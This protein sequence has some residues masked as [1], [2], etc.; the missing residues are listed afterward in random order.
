MRELPWRHAAPPRGIGLRA[1]RRRRREGRRQVLP[2]P[3]A[4]KAKTAAFPTTVTT[5]FDPRL[6]GLPF[7]NLGDYASEG[8]CIGMSLLAVDSY[9]RRIAAEQ[10]G[11][12]PATAPTLPDNPASVDME[13]RDSVTASL[14]Q[15]TQVKNLDSGADN[16][17]EELKL[18]NPKNIR[19]ALERSREDQ[20]SRDH[21]PQ[22]GQ[23][24][25]R[26]GPLRLQGREAPDLRSQ[27]PGGDG[28]VAVRPGEGPRPP[29]EGE[30]RSHVLRQAQARREHALRPVPDGARYRGDPLVVRCARQGLRRALRDGHGEGRASEQRRPPTS[31]GQGLG[32]PQEDGRRHEAREA[33]ERLDRRERQDRRHG[34]RGEGRGPSGCRCPR[35]SSTS[36]RTT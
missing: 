12:P 23:R 18:S 24:R 14:A 19:A 9:K 36:P 35:R 3:A 20:R 6:H 29:P 21:D 11:A 15:E 26:D 30:G 4:P 10:A 7:P 13:G 33:E 34:S 2:L 28:R 16:V 25:P 32:R 27:L 8:N 22:L 1:P 31:L 17:N 5:R